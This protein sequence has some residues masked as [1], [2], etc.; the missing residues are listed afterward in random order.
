M[1]GFTTAPIGEVD[2]ETLDDGTLI[3]YCRTLPSASHNYLKYSRKENL[4]QSYLSSVR[5]FVIVRP[6]PFDMPVLFLRD[7]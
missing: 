3:L 1:Q 6:Y 7:R 4:A 5:A 2:G